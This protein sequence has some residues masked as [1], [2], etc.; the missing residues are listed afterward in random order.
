MSDPSSPADLLAV[1]NVTKRFGD[2][3]A[4]DD[5]DFDLH[6][7]EVHCL[8]GE[9]GAGKSTLIKVLSGAIRPDQG[10]ISV[11]G[12]AYSHLT[13]DHSLQLGIATIY[14]DIELVGSLTVA[15]NIFLGRERVNRFGVVDYRSQNAAAQE[16]LRSID[17]DLPVTARVESLSPAEQQ[18][19]QIVKALHVK[20]VIMVMDEPTAS[21][22]VEE[23]R[24][25]L[26]LVKRLVAQRLGIIYISHFLPEVFQIGDRV[27]VL[28]DG[29]VVGTFNVA[30]TDPG[31]I[32]KRMI[33]RE[34][35]LLH[36]AFKQSSEVVLEV[37]DLTRAGHFSKVNFSLHQG[38]ILGLGGVV[39]SGRTALLNALFGA[40]RPDRGQIL[41][42][43]RAVEFDSP[44]QAIAHGFAMLP[45]D[46]TA[47]A[48]F[49]LRSVLENAAIVDNEAHGWLLN[50]RRENATVRDLV[51]RL[52]IVSSGPN[53]AAGSLSGGNQ[54]KVVLGRWLSGEA[55]IYLFDE[56]T[57]GVDVGAKEQIYRLML[58]LTSQGKSI[59]MV[60]SDIPELLTI[61]DRIVVMRNGEV[62]VT[63]RTPEVTQ[64]E[65]LGFFIGLTG[66]GE[67]AGGQLI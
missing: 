64:A 43:G 44:N 33:G 11:L 57:K 48:L 28:K 42:H 12:H 49:G 8:V 63:V 2:T 40:G 15:D 9:N 7:G 51:E 67:P 54:Q 58:E 37:K 4:L 47:L 25:L 60:S 16:L 65:L 36:P 17:I 59:L 27:T 32:T 53:Q 20:A 55:Q 10:S 6:A 26:R 3:V 39:G 1:R 22:G 62:E 38:E 24:A 45:E 41:L 50:H 31:S 29:R 46:R 18:I 52:R 19:L 5:V 35:T 14:Q 30:A 61:S 21:L 23:T 66:N 34:E 56:P 13:P